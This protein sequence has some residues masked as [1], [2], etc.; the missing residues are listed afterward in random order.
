MDVEWVRRECLA[1]PFATEDMPFGDDTVVFRLYGKIFCLL[2]LDPADRMNLKA[3]PEQ[4]AAWREVYPQVQP[5]Y[6]MNKT[7]WNTVRFEGMSE[8]LLRHM[9]HH[10]FQR[11]KASLSRKLQETIN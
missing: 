3:E 6:H 9:I 7:H 10:S 11:T 8:E 4:A 2:S 5:G 1:L